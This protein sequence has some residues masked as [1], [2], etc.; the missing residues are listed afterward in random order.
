[1][2]KSQKI[3]LQMA[4]I[5]AQNKQLKQDNKALKEQLAK[6]QS[7]SG[8]SFPWLRNFGIAFFAFIA[9]LILSIGNLLFWS[10]NTVVK[11]DRYVET[12]APLIEDP[13]IQDAVANYTTEQLFKNVDVEGFTEEVLPPRASFIAPALDSQLRTYTQ[14]TLK[15]VLHNQKFQE[16]WVSVH[17]NAHRTIINAAKQHG[18]DGVIDANELYSQLSSELK[19]TKLAFLADKSLPASVGEYKIF[20]SNQLAVLNKVINNIDLWRIMAVI[21]FATFVFLAVWLSRNRRRSVIIISSLLLAALFISLLALRITRESIVTM[22]EPQ[23]VEALRR[24]WQII[25]DS[26]VVQTGIIML[27]ALL[28]IF[29]A[30]ISGPYRSAQAVKG[31]IDEL[32]A[33]KLHSAIFGQS[34]NVLSLWLGSHKRTLK[35]VSVVLTAV[36]AMFIRLTP[37]AV[38][39]CAVIA[40]VLVL[41]I[42]VVAAPQT[43]STRRQGR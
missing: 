4:R 25:F 8:A 5:K 37:K 43:K 14:K 17:E 39:I 7:G 41:I 9:V 22:A 21:F 35:W 34:E 12:V 2:V 30:W 11:T 26:F 6:Q 16:V 19:N 1:M 40:L 42:E 13:V 18:E 3:D 20:E 33:G 31:R 36:V 29:T 38:V 27:V 32:F 23:Y 24:V 15:T 28:A 10:G